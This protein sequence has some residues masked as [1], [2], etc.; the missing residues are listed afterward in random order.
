MPKPIT[1][2]LLRGATLIHSFQMVP[3]TQYD[4]TSW[5]HAT[6]VG[7]DNIILNTGKSYVYLCNFNEYKYII[8]Y[9]VVRLK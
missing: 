1:I 4:S 6:K 3:A 2:F 7:R 9:Y 8:M 5:R